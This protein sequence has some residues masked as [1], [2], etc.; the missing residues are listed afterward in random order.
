MFL[1][2]VGNLPYDVQIQLLRALQERKIRP[3]GAANDITIDVRIIVATNE[4]LEAAIAAGRF[5]ED[6]YHRLDEFMLRM[7]PCGN[8]T[9]TCR[10]TWNI[11]WKTPT[12]N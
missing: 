3:V 7:P 2:E 1:D 4:N 9:A 8:G 5:R 10:D 6:L 11:S 12:R